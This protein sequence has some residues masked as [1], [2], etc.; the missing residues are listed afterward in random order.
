M[1][2]NFNI[3]L[4]SFDSLIGS[5]E[6]S[7]INVS[8]DKLHAFKNHPFKVLDDDKMQELVES[9]RDNGV[10][11]PAVARERSNGEYEL[12]SGHRRKHACEL[13]GIK[14]MPVFV[15]NLTDDEATIIMVDSN[16]QRE[17]LLPSEK[18]YAYKM[19]LEA[20]KRKGGRPKNDAQIEQ[21]IN[22]EAIEV[23]KL[24]F[25]STINQPDYKSLSA[26][27]RVEYLKQH[28]KNSGGT[29]EFDYD[30]DCSGKDVALYSY[31]KNISYH[32]SW[33]KVVKLLQ[34]HSSIEMIAMEVGE[35]RATIQRFIRLTNLISDLLDLVDNKQLPVN[36]GVELSYLPTKDQE[37]VFATIEDLDIIPS[38]AQAKQI[39]EYSDKGTLSPAVVDV[40]FKKI[41]DKPVSIKLDTQVKSLFPANYSKK[42]MSDLVSKLIKEY[43]EKGGE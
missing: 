5:D 1:A 38:I 19:K 39:R 3:D 29:A 11:T 36:V 33:N 13:A 15:K 2:K 28:H 6:P 10:L 27:E 9:I 25:K 22:K 23:L 26:A 17:E 12:I 18:A 41:T 40:V 35:S 8:I 20:I 43:F 7:V 31:K 16:I 32:L 24:W 37:I 34:P 42:D 21:N 4:Q 30:V 14:K